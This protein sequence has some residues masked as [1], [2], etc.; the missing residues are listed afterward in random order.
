MG[1]IFCDRS[2][3]IDG[4]DVDNGSK[5]GGSAFFG[6]SSMGPERH[7]IRDDPY[8]PWPG[9]SL[10]A[11]REEE[12]HAEGVGDA[13]RLPIEQNYVFRFPFYIQSGGQR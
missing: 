2:Y 13:S 6:F 10:R 11:P 5:P 4:I 7:V 8:P 1:P 12:D 3:G 9:S